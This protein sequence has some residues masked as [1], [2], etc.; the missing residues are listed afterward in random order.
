MCE[1]WVNESLVDELDFW[2]EFEKLLDKE[3]PKREKTV[4]GVWLNI[5]KDRIIKGEIIDKLQKAKD[6]KAL[7]QTDDSVG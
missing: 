4:K 2:Q 1:S 5:L 3:L 7:N 6:N